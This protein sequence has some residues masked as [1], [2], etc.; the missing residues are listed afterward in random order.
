MT[1]RGNAKLLKILRRQMMQIFSTDAIRAERRLIL[2]QI[3][4]PQP[5]RDIHRR[6][7]WL[8]IAG[9][10]A[11]PGSNVYACSRKRL[12]LCPPWLDRFRSRMDNDA[13]P[14]WRT[15]PTKF[16][17]NSVRFRSL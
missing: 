10:T 13:C 6:F 17:K 7:L 1:D 11:S 16:S 2:F 14:R 5:R 9:N 4:F 8:G 12:V 15:V 3:E